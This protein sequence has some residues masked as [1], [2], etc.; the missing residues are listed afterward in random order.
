MPA[1]NHKD[2]LLNIDSPEGH[3]CVHQIKAYFTSRADAEV[4]FTATNGA[5]LRVR[6]RIGGKEQ[7]A[8]TMYWQK[9][10]QRFFCRLYVGNDECRMPS[11]E[12]FISARETT[13]MGEPLR[14]EFYY[15]PGWRNG[16][17]VNLIDAAIAQLGE[18]LRE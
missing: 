4:H 11:L 1:I 12:S 14:C 10:E 13:K 2:F 3:E 17:L 15:K 7:N 18:S 5:D 9:R 6:A 16:A 8:F